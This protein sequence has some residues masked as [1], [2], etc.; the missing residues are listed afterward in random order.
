MT[1]LGLGYSPLTRRIQISKFKKLSDF[2]TVRVGKAPL[3]DVTE[4][5]LQL[6]YQLVMD[7]GGVISWELDNGD[8]MVLSAKL[9]TADSL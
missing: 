3:V 2:S 4:L 1:K 9:V 7:E 5:A 8:V 6:S